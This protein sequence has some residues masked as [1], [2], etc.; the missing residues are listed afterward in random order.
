MNDQIA[1]LI[2]EI[3]A[4]CES[5]DVDTL[6]EYIDELETSVT[7]LTI[8]VQNMELIIQKSNQFL[9][10]IKPILADCREELRKTI[11][12]RTDLIDKLSGML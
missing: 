9:E 3:R 11:P 5:I 8:N 6:S 7:A 2:E 12:L 10:G 4:E 1:Q